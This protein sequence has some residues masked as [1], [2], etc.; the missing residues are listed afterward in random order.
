[1]SRLSSLLPRTI[2][3]IS[4]LL[5]VLLAGCASTRQLGYK[6]LVCDLDR[7]SELKISTYPAGFG[8][9]KVSIPF[10]YKRNETHDTVCFQVFVRDKNRKVGAN[11]H[12]E[13]I[14]IKSFSYQLDDQP[15][16]QL[17]NNYASNFW[18]QNN[19][20]YEKRKLPPIPYQQGGV[21]AVEIDLTLNG[22]DYS[23]EG[24]MPAFEKTSS[25]PLALEML[26]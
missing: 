9:T 19:T 8:S 7:K 20:Q 4:C 3:R 11:P 23:F 18:M 12:V 22:K 16:R 5:A 26:R 21:V 17:L 1:M 14:L 25:Y 2:G 24:E 6:P 13:S 10:V 15:R